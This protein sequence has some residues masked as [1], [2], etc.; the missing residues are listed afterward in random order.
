MEEKLMSLRHKR[1][2]DIVLEEHPLVYPELVVENSSEDAAVNV[3]AAGEDESVISSTTVSSWVTG[4]T[5]SKYSFVGNTEGETHYVGKQ[6]SNGAEINGS[7][8]AGL[9]NSVEVN[10]SGTIVPELYYIGDSN[11]NDDL[12]IGVSVGDG[13]DPSAVTAIRSG[14]KKGT[15]SM[16]FQP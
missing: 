16:A 4:G 13:T 3:F 9:M 10:I 1:L 11:T 8:T 6:A 12:T 15:V 5:D 7:L 14:I 2:C